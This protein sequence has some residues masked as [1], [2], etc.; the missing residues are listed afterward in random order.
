[1][2]ARARSAL[3]ESVAG[4]VLHRA[5]ALGPM[6]ELGGGL[7]AHIAANPPGA[8]PRGRP[9]RPTQPQLTFADRGAAYGWC[10]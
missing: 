5:F 10:R 4:N 2:D 9:C 1:V 6:G 8:R 7:T 3:E